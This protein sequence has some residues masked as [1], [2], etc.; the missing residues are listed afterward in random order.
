[1]ITFL[2]CIIGGSV[3][4]VPLGLFLVVTEPG[5]Q[6]RRTFL[7]G[8]VTGACLGYLFALLLLLDNMVAWI[9]R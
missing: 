5:G 2:T 7:T 4:G 3:L 8:P 1:M 6:M 9:A